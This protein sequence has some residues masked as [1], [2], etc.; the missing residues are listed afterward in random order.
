VESTIATVLLEVGLGALGQEM[1][2]GGL[3]GLTSGFEAR[4]CG[5]RT[6]AD[7]CR[8]LNGRGRI[9]FKS[10]EAARYSS[11]HEDA[12]LRYWLGSSDEARHASEAHGAKDYEHEKSGALAPLEGPRQM[13]LGVEDLRRLVPTPRCT[14]RVARSPA[15][16]AAHLTSLH[17]SRLGLSL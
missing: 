1:T 2:P 3:E 7:G 13:V 4:G 16:F 8:S 5:G 15:T 9:N 12:A 17:P 14:P 10:A 11:T 6:R